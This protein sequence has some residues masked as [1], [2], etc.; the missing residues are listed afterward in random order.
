MTTAMIAPLPSS[1]CPTRRTR[2]PHS[3]KSSACCAREPAFAGYEWCLTEIHDP[4][5]EEHLRIKKE[6]ETGNALPDIAHTSEVCDALRAAGFD[7]L[8]S[9]DL[10]TESDPETPWYRALQGRDFSIASIPR[11]PAGRFLTN[12]TLRAAERVRLVPKGTTEVSTILNRGA[13]VPGRR[14]RVRNFHAH[15]F[16]P[17]PQTRARETDE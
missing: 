14:R 1:P 10:A 8:E 5:N 16:L 15:V 17:G 2:Q 13:D 3:G 9:R 7:L 11:T 4:R 12:L 6:I